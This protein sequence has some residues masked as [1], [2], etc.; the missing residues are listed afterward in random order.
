M[1]L[2]RRMNMDLF[3]ASQKEEFYCFAGSRAVAIIQI[4][5]IWRDKISVHPFNRCHLRASAK[6]T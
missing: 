6:S 3:F 1:I 5:R 4:I 2:I